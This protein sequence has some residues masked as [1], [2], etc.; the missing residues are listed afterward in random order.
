MGEIQEEVR[1]F[2]EESR[3]SKAVELGTQ[4]SLTEWEK[5]K[6]KVTW[7]ELWR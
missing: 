5:P 6:R 7:A 1:N 3:R 4:G 2:E